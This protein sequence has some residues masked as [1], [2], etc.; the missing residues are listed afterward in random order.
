MNLLQFF[1]ASTQTVKNH[2]MA[3]GGHAYLVAARDLGTRL[4]QASTTTLRQQKIM[5]TLRLITLTHRF[6]N[7]HLEDSLFLWSFPWIALKVLF[8]GVG[9]E[10]P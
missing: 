6:E 4:G 9:V 3:V 8:L 5:T 7:I 2:I 10:L 1:V